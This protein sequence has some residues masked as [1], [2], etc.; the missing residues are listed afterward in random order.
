[1]NS[2]P[3]IKHF[4]VISFILATVTAAAVSATR[5]DRTEAQ[6]NALAIRVNQA[7]LFSADKT[8]PVSQVKARSVRIVDDPRWRRQMSLRE[9]M[10]ESASVLVGIPHWNVCQRSADGQTI[11]TEYHV[12]V[13]QV[14]KGEGI[15]GSFITVSLPGGV[16]GSG[17]NTVEEVRTPYFRKMVNGKTYA[18]FLNDAPDATNILTPTN[19]PQGLFELPADGSKVRH[20]GRPLTLPPDDPNAP[21][22]EPFL[23][24]MHN[25]LKE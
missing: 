12:E 8:R 23:R 16:A 21:G 11:T 3:R 6:P 4:L 14:I 17:D 10:R 15:A 5:R 9:L 20:H 19:G 1:M 13:K 7:A 2:N 18:L 25:A 24:E 22:V